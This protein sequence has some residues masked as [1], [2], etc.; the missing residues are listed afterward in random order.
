MSKE[1]DRILKKSDYFK[2]STCQHL[3]KCVENIR[4]NMH[5]TN[6]T[7]RILSLTHSLQVKLLFRIFLSSD[8]SKKNDSLL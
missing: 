3:R 5:R 8:L 1:N 2:G 4:E 6:P 7:V